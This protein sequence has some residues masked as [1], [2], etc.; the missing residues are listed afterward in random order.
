M[1]NEFK[2][3]IAPEDMKLIIKNRCSALSDTCN[4]LSSF[5]LSDDHIDTDLIYNRFYKRL[6]DLNRD[7]IRYL[8][9]NK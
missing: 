9:K 4:S 5:C 8:R 2:N 7:I 1:E 3:W 6:F